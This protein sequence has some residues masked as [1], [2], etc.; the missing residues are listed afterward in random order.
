MN[1]SLILI[2]DS[3]IIYAGGMRPYKIAEMDRIID[4]VGDTEDMKPDIDS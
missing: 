2:E 4:V 1:N 3:E